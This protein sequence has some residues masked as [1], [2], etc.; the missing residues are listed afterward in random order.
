M[1]EGLGVAAAER[2]HAAVSEVLGV[3]GTFPVHCMKPLV[4]GKDLY[5]RVAVAVVADPGI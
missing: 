2:G 4:K 1:E 3:G 5:E